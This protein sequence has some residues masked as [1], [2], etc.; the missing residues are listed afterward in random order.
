LAADPAFAAVDLDRALA[1]QQFVGLAPRQV[2]DFLSE[3]IQPI[4]HRYRSVRRL[5]AA[6]D[7]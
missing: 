4:L 7:V 2:D 5:D 1:P 6:L 3:V